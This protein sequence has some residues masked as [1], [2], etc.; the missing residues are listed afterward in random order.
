M[1]VHTDL[2]L[3]PETLFPQESAKAPAQ[4]KVTPEDW[5]VTEE[6]DA[7]FTNAGEHRYFFIE[8]RCL[9]TVP[10]QRG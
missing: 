9:S 3:A 5:Q 2:V 8:K 7:A 4:M 1:M 10:W 6:L